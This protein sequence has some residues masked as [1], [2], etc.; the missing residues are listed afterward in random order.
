MGSVGGGG[1]GLCSVDKASPGHG[2]TTKKHI[3]IRLLR[4]TDTALHKQ[5]MSR[6]LF[7]LEVSDAVFD[8]FP[9]SVDCLPGD[10]L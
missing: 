1:V 2:H 9:V 7:L 3:E 8:G 4:R 6:G 5:L 10:C